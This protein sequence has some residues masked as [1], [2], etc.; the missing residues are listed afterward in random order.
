MENKT[1]H[2]DISPENTGDI[3]ENAGVMWEHNATTIIFNIASAYV[4]NYKYYLEYRSLIGTKV[5]T[6]YLEFN[7]EDNTITYAVPVSM[8]SLRGIECYFNIVEINE[9]GQTTAVIKPKKFCLEF[10]FSPDTDNSLAKLNDFSINALMEAIRLGTFKGADAI[11]DNEMTDDSENAVKSKVVKAYID[12]KLVD[13]EA[14]LDEII[15]LQNQ[16][17]GGNA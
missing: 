5:R 14:V 9:D 10:D 8:T 12:E 2:I 15:T 16:L 7:A 17:I 4:G 3:S 11:V 1:I 13:V 6:E